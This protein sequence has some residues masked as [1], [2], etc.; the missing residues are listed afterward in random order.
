MAAQRVA[1]IGAGA[2]GSYF[3][4]RLAE[5]GHDVRFLM[6]RDYEAVAAGGLHLSSPLGGPGDR[7]ADDCGLSRGAG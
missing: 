7:R 5:A 6:R 2:V 3:G 1:V 4:M